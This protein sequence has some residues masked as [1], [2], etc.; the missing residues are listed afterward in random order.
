M[1]YVVTADEMRALD[2]ATI[3]DMGLPGAVLMENAGRRVGE[4]ILR[5]LGGNNLSAA[6]TRARAAV[7]CGAGNN[8]G[9]GYVIGRYL[10]DHGVLATVYLCAPADRL[11]G[12]ARLH[13]L[14]Y[15]AMGH[16]VR[17]IVDSESLIDCAADIESA[18][19]VVDSIFGTGLARPIGGHYRA[20]V[21]TLNRARGTRVAVDIPSG[22]CA[23]SGRVLGV[24]V[25]ADVTVTMAFLKAGLASAPGFARAGRVQ[26]AEIGIPV[27]LAEKRGVCTVLTEACDLGALIPAPGPLEHKSRRGHLLVVAGS[28][29]KRG[30]ARLTAWAGLRAGAGLVTLASSW[31]GIEPG[32]PDPVMTEDLDSGI[33][34]SG[35]RLL[36]LLGGKR[37]L[38][39]GPGMSTDADGKVLV[40]RALAE[41]PVPVVLD[42]DALNHLGTDLAAV[43]G[44]RAPVVMTPHPGEAARLLGV[45][46]ADIER[47]RLTA[48]RSL[49][50]ASGAVIVLKGARSLV[51]DGRAQSGGWV[52]INPTGNVGLATAGSG[53][54]LTG[55]V[56]ALL[57]QG[58]DPFDAARLA[59]FVHGRTGELAA[60]ALGSTQAVTA[61]DLSQYLA[62]AM[63]ELQTRAQ[64]RE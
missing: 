30:A 46:S 49:A 60:R 6:R 42:A 35:R 18:D 47:D 10:R 62:P 36:D 63:S 28:P 12:D 44:A 22:L 27:R 4:A 29:G 15:R 26:V 53:D 21:E 56:G 16:P 37:A 58:L 38:A 24:A 23:D 9:D 14:A 59:A 52:A 8:G 41:S 3:D 57:A 55:V 50:R 48:A 34:D 31:A 33:E 32:A 25:A 45:S 39:I 7:V 20:V 64:R 1:L 54:V 61:A 17:D 5:E 51:A 43:A 40:Y 2:A 13:Y 11:R 19:I